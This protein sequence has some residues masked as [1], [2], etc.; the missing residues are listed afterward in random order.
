M[1]LVDHL[2]VNKNTTPTTS[3]TTTTTTTSTTETQLCDFQQFFTHSVK[4]Q[5][6]F[7]CPYMSMNVFNKKKIK[8]SL[9][10]TQAKVCTEKKLDLIWI[11]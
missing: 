5:A 6:I 8:T 1:D 3:T 9:E 11:L 2:D 4:E 7:V 10:T